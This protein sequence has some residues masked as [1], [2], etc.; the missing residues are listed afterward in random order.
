MRSLCV[1]ALPLYH[2]CTTGANSLKPS[3]LAGPAPRAAADNAADPVGIKPAPA[4][5]VP[6]CGVGH[7]GGQ[8]HRDVLWQHVLAGF[9]AAHTGLVLHRTPCTGC[10]FDLC[11]PHGGEAEGFAL[12]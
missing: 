11:L 6:G 9:S 8:L 4:T 3:T 1:Y 5:N 12:K 7:A 10:V 2:F